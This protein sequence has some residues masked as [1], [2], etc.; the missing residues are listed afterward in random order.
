MGKT[1]TTNNYRDALFVGST[2]GPMELPWRCASDSMTTAHWAEWKPAAE[3]R[4]RIQRSHA[5]DLSSKAGWPGAGLSRKHG[6]QHCR[7]SEWQLCGKEAMR[8]FNSPDAGAAE[9]DRVRS[10]RAPGTILAT[11]VCELPHIPCLSFTSAEMEVAGSY[12]ERVKELPC[13]LRHCPLKKTKRR[14]LC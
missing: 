5:E 8:F 7:I 1:G 11:N 2:Y 4:F 12:Y 3:R 6:E 10:C 13:P 9:D 14:A